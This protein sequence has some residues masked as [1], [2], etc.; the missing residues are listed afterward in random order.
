MDERA[1]VQ[2][3]FRY[4]LALRPRREDAED[5]V[6][7][8]CLR[9]YR[10]F[11]HLPDRPLLLTTIRNIYIDQYRRD[12]L[13]LFEPLPDHEPGPDGEAPLEA[14]L[15]VAALAEPLARLRPEE[16]EALFLSAVEEYSASE[17]ATLTHRTRGTILS[18]IH[19]AR[20]KL[21]KALTPAR[22]DPAPPASRR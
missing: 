18:L 6:Q 19:R 3:G 2:A 13:V 11:G 9:L 15:T 21:R 17:I 10:R 14:S 20:Q 16:R 5:L 4:A 12:K 7:E 8:A 1:L 22:A